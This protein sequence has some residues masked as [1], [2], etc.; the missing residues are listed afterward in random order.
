Q[1]AARRLG[2]PLHMV[3]VTSADTQ[4][5]RDAGTT[6]ATR[7]TYIVGNAVVAAAADLQQRLLA[8][9]ERLEGRARTG[10]V[11]DSAWLARLEAACR[12]HGVETEAVG[13][14]S[15]PTSN[16]DENGQGTP[17]GIYSFGAQW[18]RVLVDLATYQVKVE[19]VVACYD[20]GQII[21]PLLLDGQVMGGTVMGLGFGLT[22]E[23]VLDKGIMVN[24]SFAQ[25]ILPGIGDVPKITPVIL[26]MADPA[27]PFG[28]KGIAEMTAVPGAASMANAVSAALG[29]D[30]KALPLTP[31]R[32]FA[33]VQGA[34]SAAAGD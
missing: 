13:R 28:A 27:G 9:A 16:L 32:L 12:G 2:V 18:S 25:Y 7:I 24:P 19:R 6:T 5:T 1:L 23:V 33:A 8:E 17:Y 3:R 14:F 30:V 4:L 21:N 15:T 26:E 22:E 10:L 34:K 11:D 29:V 31:E 20:V